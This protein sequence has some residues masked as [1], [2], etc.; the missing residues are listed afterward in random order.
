M[1]WGWKFEEN[2]VG[3]VSNDEED[4]LGNDGL[5]EGPAPLQTVQ[6]PEVI[7]EGVLQKDVEE[8]ISYVAAENAFNKLDEKAVSLASGGLLPDDNGIDNQAR[9]MGQLNQGRTT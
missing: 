1:N 5:D 3:K 7:F 6:S 4:V 2:N 9:Y 8:R